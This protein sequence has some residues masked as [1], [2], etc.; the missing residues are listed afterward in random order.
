MLRELNQREH[1]GLTVTLLWDASDDTL[2]VT[3]D[4][5]RTGVRFE[6]RDVPKHDAHDAFH[7]PFAYQPQLAGQT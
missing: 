6:L 5:A 1:D 2:Q 3:V 7:H 4:D